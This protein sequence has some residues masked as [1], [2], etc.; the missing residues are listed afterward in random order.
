MWPTDSFWGNALIFAAAGY[1]LLLFAGLGSL[2]GRDERGR[3]VLRMAPL[4]LACIIL[5]YVASALLLTGLQAEDGCIY[6]A[7]HPSD[8]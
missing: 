7:K 3:K 2:L 8:C 1:G 6:D 4:V 5:A